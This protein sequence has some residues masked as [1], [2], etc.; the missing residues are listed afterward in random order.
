MTIHDN[1]TL[2]D[3]RAFFAQDRF[4]TDAGMTVE[5][6]HPGYARCSVTLDERHRNAMGGV[7]GGVHFTLA[8]LAFA[9]AS[10]LGGRPTVNVHSSIQYLSAVKGEILT[11]EAHCR[12]DGRSLCFYDVELTSEGRLC[13]LVTI[14]GSHV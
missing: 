6:A 4:A 14:T 9:V 5:E 1:M 8:D 2:E 3:V 13:A 10:N 7:M 11:A 12:K